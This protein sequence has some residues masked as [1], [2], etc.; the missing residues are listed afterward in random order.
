MDRGCEPARLRRALAGL[1]LPRAAD[2]RIVLAVDVSNW[3]S[4][5]AATSDDRLLCH[6]CGR[7]DRSQG[8]VRARLAVLLPG[9][10][11]DRPDFLDCVA[12]RRSPGTGGRRDSGHGHQLRDMSTE[13]MDSGQWREGDPAIWVVMDSG[14]DIALLTYTL[15]DLPVVLVGRLR[16]DRV[17]LP[18]AGSAP[19]V[20]K[21]PASQARRRLLPSPVRQLAQTRG[22]HGH[23]H[24]PLRQGRGDG[25]G[26]H[27]PPT[28]PPRPLA[29]PGRRKTSGTARH[30][31]ACEGRASAGRPRPET[32]PALDLRDGRPTGGCEPL[33]A[34][35]S[36]DSTSNT[37]SG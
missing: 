24:H 23:R 4:P 7:G 31:D 26:P 33:V 10:S 27:A 36:A 11:G 37:P 14:Y 19:G 20:P 22:H 21:G 32:S 29:G 35:I 12:G 13:L 1:P 18:D 28:H 9:S 30:V 25:L 8:Q 2:G 16:S 34:G 15:A 6:V 17:M 3:L 5:D